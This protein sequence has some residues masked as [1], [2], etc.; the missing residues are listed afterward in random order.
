MLNEA[1]FQGQL[2]SGTLNSFFYGF[3]KVQACTFLQH[4]SFL[5]VAPILLQKGDDPFWGSTRKL[6]QDRSRVE[7]TAVPPNLC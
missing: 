6:L 4:V 7:G 5:K 1:L 3:H 2:Y